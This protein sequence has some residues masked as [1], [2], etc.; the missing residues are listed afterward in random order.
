MGFGCPHTSADDQGFD[1]FDLYVIGHKS[2]NLWLRPNNRGHGFILVDDIRYAKLYSRRQASDVFKKVRNDDYAIM[3]YFDAH[4]RIGLVN[5]CGFLPAHGSWPNIAYNKYD[6]ND[7]DIANFWLKYF[8]SP[9]IFLQEYLD[10]WPSLEESFVFFRRVSEYDNF[11]GGKKGVTLDLFL[12][13]ESDYFAFEKELKIT[14]RC[15][16]YRE[17]FYAVLMVY[18]TMDE[19]PHYCFY[20]ETYVGEECVI[21]SADSSTVLHEGDVESCFD[22]MIEHMFMND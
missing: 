7:I 17:S 22:Y 10:T 2:K 4:C 12:D 16:V 21:R 14:R 13:K 20:Y 5:N 6:H 11:H 8:K 3:N 15:R 9:E 19:K 18:S 1:K